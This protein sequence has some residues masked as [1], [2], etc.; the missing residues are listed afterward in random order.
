[1]NNLPAEISNRIMRF[2]FHPI[3]DLFT[4]EIKTNEEYIHELIDYGHSFS[5]AYFQIYSE[6]KQMEE[7][8]MNEY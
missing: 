8:R 2:V 3:T 1:M 6:I 7:L 5:S 4:R